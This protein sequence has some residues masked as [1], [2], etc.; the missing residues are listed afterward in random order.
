V[1]FDSLLHSERGEIF[2]PRLPAVRIEDVARAM[3][4]DRDI[5]IEE[6]GIRPGEK[7]HEIMVSEEES[8]RTVMRKGTFRESYYAIASILPE[9][10]GEAG[11]SSIGGEYSSR[12]D[13]RDFDEVAELL[14]DTGFIERIGQLA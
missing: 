2:V 1:V 13:I 9:V 7:V 11:E 10:S 14:K 12:I 8:T 4:G 6:L 5:S 3:I